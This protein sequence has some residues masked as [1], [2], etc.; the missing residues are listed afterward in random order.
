MQ[1]EASANERL[2]INLNERKILTTGAFITAAY[3]TI[4]DA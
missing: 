4:F 2:K 3:T 1:H